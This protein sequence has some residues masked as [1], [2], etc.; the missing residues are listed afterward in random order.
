M[1]QISITDP[2]LLIVLQEWM[3]PLESSISTGSKPLDALIQGLLEYDPQEDGDGAAY[4]AVLRNAI[5]V[6]FGVNLSAEDM[7]Q[8][9]DSFRVVSHLETAQ[10]TMYLGQAAS[11]QRMLTTPEPVSKASPFDSKCVYL[12]RIDSSV[13]SYKI[14]VS[15][16]PQARAEAIARV[17]GV[18]THLVH[19]FPAADALEAERLLHERF[20]EKRLQGEYFDLAPEDVDWLCRI[21]SYQN[22]T[23]LNEWVGRV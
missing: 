23:F 22:G 15:A 5:E 13:T 20:A 6:E 8:A 2:R 7:E 12:F 3:R 4:V 9:I 10:R 14:G 17:A 19:T 18:N 11:L 1:N 21:Q 16:D